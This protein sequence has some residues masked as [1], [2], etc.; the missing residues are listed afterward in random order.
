MMSKINNSHG[1]KKAAARALQVK[2][3]HKSA[4]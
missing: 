1:P 4:P 2:H 3:L